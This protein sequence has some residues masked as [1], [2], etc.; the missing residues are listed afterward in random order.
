MRPPRITAL[1]ACEYSGR[2]RD[3][4]ITNGIDAM[5]CDWTYETERP[6]PH[7]KGD[8][9]DVLDAG[10][11]LMIA[12]P[13]CTYLANSGVQHLHKVPER[14]SPKVLYGPPRWRALEEA[15]EFFR[16]LLNADIPL[17]GVE[18]PIP[19]GYAVERIGRKYDQV[20]QPWMFGDEA[21]KATCFWLKNLPPLVPTKIVGPPPKDPVER[22]KW[23]K[24]HLASPGPER[25]KERSRTYEGLAEAIGKQWGDYAKAMRK[26]NAA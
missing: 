23:A 4:L 20:V 25:W 1:V 8:V 7:Y 16:F 6:G 10:F 9:R 24:V 12:H 18:N 22:R 15:T 26:E 14:P 13:D 11:D 2:V 3:A 19:H 5:S 21:M 17:I